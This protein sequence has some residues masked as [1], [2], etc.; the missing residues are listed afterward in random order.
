QQKTHSMTRGTDKHTLYLST[1]VGTGLA[2]VRK[3]VAQHAISNKASN[4][5]NRAQNRAAHQNRRQHPMVRLPWFKPK[6]AN[7]IPTLTKSLTIPAGLTL[8]R[9]LEGHTDWVRSMMWSPDGKTLASVSDD[10]TIRLWDST[11]GML[12]QTLKGHTDEVWSVDWSPDGKTLV[13]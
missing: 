12:L 9:T 13:S 5:T 8:L 4:N 3:M 7:A 11:A 2:P 1:F 10:K 6:P